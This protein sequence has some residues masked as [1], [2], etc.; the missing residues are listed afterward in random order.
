MW[1]TDLA[2]EM[3]ESFPGDEKEVQGVVLTKEKLEEETIEITRVEIK[4]EKGA[5]AMGKPRGTY[6]TIESEFL[7]EKKEFLVET[8]KEYLWE[9]S[10]EITGKRILVAGLGN[11]EM[12][13]DSLGPYVVENLFVT[14]HLLREFGEDFRKKYKMENVSAIVPGVMGQTGMESSEILKGIIRETK[15]ELLIVVDALAAR[16][17]NRVN[18]TIQ[19]TDTGICPGAGIG[20]N[21]KE[22]NQKNLGIPVIAVGVPTVVDAAT[23]VEDRMELA[24]K[25]EGYE[26]E[27]IH[28]FL[29]SLDY[30]S[31]GSFFVT[32]KTVDEEIRLMGDIISEALNMGFS[33]IYTNG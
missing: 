2:L 17:L 29:G 11:R 6:V 4:D 19:L 8:L 28:R 32:P 26:K 21:R 16:N 23:I 3:R 9:L 31:M 15:P 30:R 7:E 27:E 1:R 12:T 25:K 13:P 18:K 10:G 5:R 22:L 33:N 24:L 20:N 14:R